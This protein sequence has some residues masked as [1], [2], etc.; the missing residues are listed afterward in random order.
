MQGTLLR[1]K[2]V[3][4]QRY[5]ETNRELQA[6]LESEGADVDSGRSINVAQLISGWVRY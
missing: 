6:A 3:V 5:G 2:R 4:V 1:G